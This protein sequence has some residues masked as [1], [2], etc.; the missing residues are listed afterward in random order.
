M[1]A[2]L[3]PANEAARVHTLHSYRVLDT[4]PEPSF[5]EIVQLAARL[6]ASPVA[7]LALV[8]TNRLWCK[9]RV[10]LER[11]AMPR[12]ESFCAHAILGESLFE[13]ADA[14][15][16][17]RF[18]GSALVA[19]EPFARSYAGVPLL[20]PEGYT[21][22]TLCVMHRQPRQLAVADRA[23]L[24]VLAHAAM[25][26]LELRRATSRMHELTMTDALTGLPNRPALMDALDRSI[27]RLR[28]QGQSFALLHFDIDGFKAVNDALGHAAG[29]R[30]LRDLGGMLHAAVRREDVPARIGGDE[31]M[32]LLDGAG[33]TDLQAAAERLRDTLITAMAGQRWHV[34]VSVGAVRFLQAPADAGQALAVADRLLREAKAGGKTRIRIGLFGADCAAA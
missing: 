8:D 21:L 34:A 33:R 27:A 10:G 26:A 14:A 25:T 22:G 32:I 5:D 7:L 3:L 13:V 12:E 2:A 17:S 19:A 11:A 16:D 24:I 1:Q 9:S 4:P 29:D 28:R 6:T 31:F 20:N 15:A 23:A 30:L 18:A